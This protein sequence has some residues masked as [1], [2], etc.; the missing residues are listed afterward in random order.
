MFYFFFVTKLNETEKKA[1]PK[2]KKKLYTEP[3][4]YGVCKDEV[5]LVCRR[6]EVNHELQGR[7]GTELC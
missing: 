5:R 4:F 2:K 1:N 3:K 6:R 7:R